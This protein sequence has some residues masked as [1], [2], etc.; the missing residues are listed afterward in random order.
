[1]SSHDPDSQELEGRPSR[2]AFVVLAGAGVAALGA[3]GIAATS[4]FLRPQ[5]PAAPGAGAQPAAPAQPAEPAQPAWTRGSRLFS[6]DSPWNT[7]IPQNPAIDPASAAVQKAVLRNPKL[8][9][10]TILYSYGIPFYTATA[11]T[12]RRQLRGRGA[13]DDP[14]P[15]D[16]SWRPNAGGDRKMNVLDPQR[17]LVYELQGYDAANRSAYWAVTRDIVNDKGDGG[18]SFG[19][20]GPTGSGLSQA[21]GVVRIDEI[22]AGRIDHAL[23]FI[24]ADPAR[25]FRYPATHGDGSNTAAGA[26][27][28]GMRVQLDPAL[29]LTTLDLT[30]AERAIGRALQ[31]YGAF[32]SDTGRGNNMAMGF[33]MEKPTAGTG[34]PY[35]A[36][37]LPEDWAQL[38]NIPRSA[39][40]VLA[41]SVTKR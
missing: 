4:G 36:A 34:D 11:S 3:A 30:D 29:D 39:Y 18:T 24:T 2:R 16:P 6:A 7:P 14:I 13:F 40:R 9:V 27:Q 21:A 28:E 35:K 19:R 41:A 20:T 33:Y 37:G 5:Q 22:R 31:V 32:C 12:P 25:G 15:L 10:N 38:K 23:S 26:I 1:M 17:G 8:V